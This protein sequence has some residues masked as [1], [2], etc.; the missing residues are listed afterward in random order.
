MHMYCS[1][2][3]ALPL[4][5]KVNSEGKIL[6]K[7]RIKTRLVSIAVRRL[8]TQQ[9]LIGREKSDSQKSRGGYWNPP[10]KYPFFAP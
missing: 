10:F 4:K 2:N 9:R 6:E 7:E 5:G 3:P 8:L 1:N